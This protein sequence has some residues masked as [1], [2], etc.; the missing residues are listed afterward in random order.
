MI[1][2]QSSDGATLSLYTLLNTLIKG[3]S[4]GLVVKGGNLCSEDCEFESKHRKLDGHFFTF[5][6]C[7][8]CNGCLKRRK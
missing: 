1:D 6:C 8:N 4:P 7:K 5:N 3:S 2:A